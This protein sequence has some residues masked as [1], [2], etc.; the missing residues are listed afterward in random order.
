MNKPLRMMFADD[1]M[2]RK[3]VS[4]KIAFSFH[5]FSLVR[6]FFYSLE[7]KR[8]EFFNKNKQ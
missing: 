5:S 8:E 1:S 4:K 6:L 3:I 2:A 7:R